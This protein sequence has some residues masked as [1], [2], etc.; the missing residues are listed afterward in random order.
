MSVTC[1]Q[2]TEFAEEAG[3]AACW[4]QWQSLRGE[5]ADKHGAGAII[6]PEALVLLSLLVRHRERRLQD[7]LAWWASVGARLM[8]L[9]RMKTL[10]AQYPQT[11]L[12]DLEWFAQ[13]CT[14]AGDPRWQSLAEMIDAEVSI[15][16]RPG[17]GPDP[18]QL[19]NGSTLM[20]R[21]R[22]GFGVGA[23][24]DLLSFLLGSATAL[25]EREVLATAETISRAISYSSFSVRRAAADLALARL[26]RA[27]G[28]R[29]T[30]YGIVREDWS[31]LLGLEDQSEGDPGAPWKPTFPPWRFVSQVY[32]F[33]A[34]C[35]GWAETT[36]DQPPVVQASEARDIV[37]EYGQ[38][39][40]WNGIRLPEPQLHPGERYSAAFETLVE[41][42]TAWIDEKI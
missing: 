14:K 26:I 17:K 40:I 15:T 19:L 42:V 18:C 3:A 34:A 36:R 41:T 38:G 12:P 24:A 13:K 35:I 16:T 37:E 1:A 11:L 21:L 9:Q 25:G 33:I 5:G 31:H 39:L 32:A 28:D 7:M 30:D 4:R 20:L 23:K 10:L 2:I 27:S 29:P 8:S 6:D 22:A